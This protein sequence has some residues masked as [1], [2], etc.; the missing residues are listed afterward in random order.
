MKFVV[1]PPNKDYCCSVPKTEKRLPNICSK[2]GL[3][4][5]YSNMK[6]LSNILRSK[7]TAHNIKATLL[8]NRIGNLQ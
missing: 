3:V 7:N 5:E 2:S 8:N 6:E 1:L 4:S